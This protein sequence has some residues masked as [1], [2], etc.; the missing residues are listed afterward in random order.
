M[1]SKLDELRRRAEEKARE[2]DEQFKITS[3]IDKGGRA[4]TDALRKGAEKT[5]EA[6]DAARAEAARLNREHKV[7]ETIS[8][9]ARR[10][11]E[12]A[13]DVLEKSGVK[14]KAGEVVSEAAEKA[15][16]V[17][18]DA[19]DKAA[20]LFGDARRYFETA[21]GAAKTSASAVRLPTSLLSAASSARR[22]ATRNPCKAAVVSLAFIAGTR[23]GAAFSSLDM[24]LLG[25]G[26][27]GH[28][29][30]HSAL[31][32]YGLRKLSEKYEAFLRKQEELIQAGKLTEAEQ[33]RIKF[34]RDA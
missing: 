31:A 9:S 3:T 1:P 24:T 11:G 15:G 19:K 30:F 32:P 23:A 2:L 21:T 4:A 13:D 20:D 34:Q 10:V 26:G 22:W 16:S 14:K 28:W 33:S 29:L 12:A 18:S 5:T 7:T 6:L 17:A 25:A 8:E 27:A